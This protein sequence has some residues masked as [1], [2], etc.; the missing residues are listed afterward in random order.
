MK[1]KIVKLSDMKSY[2]KNPRKNE[3]AVDVVMKSIKEF[4]FKVPIILDKN[5]VIVA[6]HT[7][8]MAAERLGMKEVPAIFADD[9]N[10]KQIRAFR[11][12]DNKSQ[13]Y[14]EWDQGLLSAEF[15]F[16]SDDGFDMEM[17]GFTGKEIKSMWEKDVIEDDFEIPKEPKYDIK[18]LEV[19]ELGEN[20]LMCGDASKKEHVKTLMDGQMS[21]M[22]FTSP[23]Y[24][25]GFEYE[26]EKEKNDIISHIQKVSEVMAQFTLKRIVINT[27]N[28]S[29]ITKAQKITG[30][31]Q[32][33]LLIDWWMNQLN[34][35][36]FLLRHIRIWS[37]MGGVTPSRKI[38][39]IDMHWEYLAQFTTEE[40]DAGFIQTFYSEKMKPEQKEKTP[41]WAVKGV[42]ND[43]Q[44][45]ARQTGH[46][47][48]YPIELVGRYLKMYT[49]CESKV[50]DCYG[51]SGTTLIACEQTGRKCFMM[52]LD[53]Y[54]CSVIIERWE[55]LTKKRA[56]KIK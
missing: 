32:P 40:H 13:E 56:K 49:D 2:K 10:E 23:P 52:E 7:R 8:V 20:R 12:M 16:L 30:M 1:M 4:G 35:N 53:P 24:W 21:D 37:K 45:N 38:D 50:Y 18:E 48:A 36:K 22:I 3:L 55:K 34:K 17:T 15:K 27:G 33:A 6:G 41:S 25:V 9:L 47:A 39:K 46:V 14:A 43:I 5:S 31:K 28:I 26:K 19:W 44:G 51:G 29:S 11:I 54:Y 42:W